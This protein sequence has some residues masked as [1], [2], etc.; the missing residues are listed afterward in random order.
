[1]KTNHEYVEALEKEAV[2]YFKYDKHIEDLLSLYC[3]SSPA[4]NVTDLQGNKVD[5]KLAFVLEQLWRDNYF[6]RK[7]KREYEE[8][9]PVQTSCGISV[10]NIVKFPTKM[11]K[12]K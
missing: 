10:E 5:P 4:G 2:L 8:A 1:M 9:I 7:M 6:V 11:R 12:I 3:F